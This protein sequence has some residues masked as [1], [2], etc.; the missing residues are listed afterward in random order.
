MLVL[1][2]SSRR[3]LATTLAVVLVGALVPLIGAGPAAAQTYTL[4]IDVSHWQEEDGHTINWQKVADSGH[5][6]AWHKATEGATYSDPRYAGN[7]SEAGAVGI[8]F[9]AYHFAR[10]NGGTIAAAQSDAIGEAQYFLDVAQPVSGDLIPVLDLESNGGIP[11]RRLIAWTQAWLDHVI[12]ALDVKPLIYSGPNFWRTNMDD[13]TTFAEQGF[14]LWLAHYTSDAS[15]SV[16]AANW[17]GNGWS[18]W[19]WTSK[20]TVPGISGSVDEDRFAGSDL[21]PYK[22]PGA[23]LPEPTPDPATPPVNQSAPTISGETE[24]GHTLQAS[25]GTWAGSQPQSYS[26]AWHRCDANGLGCGGIFEGTEPTYELGPADYG[27]HLKVTVTA[28]NSAGS[29]QQDSA[30]SEAVTDTV[31]P[32]APQMTSPAARP[33][34]ASSVD[35]AWRSTEQGAAAYDARYRASSKSSGFGSYTD[36]VSDSTESKARLDV[37]GGATY[38]F[39][40]RAID[41]AGNRST[42][43]S[44]RCTAVPLDDRDLKASSA[45]ARRTGT[46]F[47][48]DTVTK[49]TSTNASIIARNVRVRD[50]YVLAQRCSGCGSVAVLFN[51]KRVGTVRLS[52]KRTINQQLIRVASFSSPRTGTVELRVIS[53]GAP[54]KIDGLLLSLRG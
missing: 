10:P 24:V 19:Q 33:A 21:T 14:P 43:S 39:S 46:A 6:F 41:E 17:N 28:T 5:V 52:A 53:A 20:A 2:A 25:S 7:R 51:G 4:G 36:L 30:L 9:G 42:W 48:L 47:Y 15:P 22:I 38:C 35:V 31:A 8:P 11:A 32:S 12:A 44:E 50:L 16:P 45:W 23:P 27:H 34:L 3:A 40:A 37:E 18:F 29:A 1:L 13:T 26:Y 49:T 54:V